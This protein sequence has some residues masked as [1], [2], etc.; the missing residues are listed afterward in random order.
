MRHGNMICGADIQNG[1][2]VRI[3]PE[4]YQQTL[5]LKRVRRMN[6]TGKPV[7]ESTSPLLKHSIHFLLHLKTDCFISESFLMQFTQGLI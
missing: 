6:L 1:L 4:K 3:G 7:Q 5:K 2:R